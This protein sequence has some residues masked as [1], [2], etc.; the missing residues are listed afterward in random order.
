MPHCAVLQKA[1]L[2]IDGSE[3]CLLLNIYTPKLSTS[4]SDGSG[5]FNF[6]FRR[7][8]RN[9]EKFPVLIYFYGGA[10]QF[11]DANDFNPA[12]FMDEDVVI[13]IPNYRVN[14]LGN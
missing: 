6:N 7:N 8:N 14:A 1:T 11:G 4:G 10:F 13:I 12:Y 9:N 5:T 2:T 3:D